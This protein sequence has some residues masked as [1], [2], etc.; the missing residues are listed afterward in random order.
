MTADKTNKVELV[1][2]NSD[3]P[4]FLFIIG[5]S[6][7]RH[8]MGMYN[9]KYNTTP[10]CQKLIDKGSMFAFTD[11]ISMKSS[12]ALVMT[13]LLTFINNENENADITKFDPIVDVFTKAGYQAFWLSNHEKITK[14]L[15][16][17]TFMSSR[18]DF[19]TF[20]SKTTEVFSDSFPSWKR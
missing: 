5:E 12:T 15:S 7:S 20:T 11:T 19:A 2:N 6:E 18:C 14:D 4:Y 16:Y 17:A 9:N 3:T 8:F 13:P 1:S 10:L